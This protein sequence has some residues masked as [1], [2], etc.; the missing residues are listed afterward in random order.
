MKP[1][2]T[3]PENHAA[4]EDSKRSARSIRS[5]VAWPGL[6]GLG[7][8]STQERIELVREGISRRALSEV[9]AALNWS[10][11]QLEAYLKA[12]PSGSS[13]RLDTYSSDRLLGLH[14]LIL[15]IARMVD[16]S[17]TPNAFDAGLWLGTWLTTP[18][19]A[20]AGKAP[21]SYLDT[22]EGIRLL[23]SLITRMESG[24]YS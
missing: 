16:D 4:P 23:E 5:D 11:P 20:L 10:A 9:A 13:K 6:D 24:A 2:H 8:L 14:A 21:G 15:Q 7:R 19:N 18:C 12:K 1:A 3:F 22:H 17:G